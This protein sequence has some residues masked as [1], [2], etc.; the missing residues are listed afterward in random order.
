METLQ[1]TDRESVFAPI[2]DRVGPEA[3]R[4]DLSLA[5][6]S[7]TQIRNAMTVDVE[8][9]FHVAAL[10]SVI[11]R[12]DW[13]R[14]EYRAEESTR[15]L[16]DLFA[17]FEISATFFVLGWV[18]RRSPALV[19]QI[20]DAGHEVACH[21]LSHELIYRQTPKDFAL[22][23]AESKSLLEDIIG[24]SVLGYRAASWSITRQSLWA[25]DVIHDL[26]FL[27]DSSIF[28]IHHDRY[29]IPGAPTRVGQVTSPSG[30]RI[31]EFPPST[32]TILGVRVPVAG[33]GYFRLLPYSLTRFG[34]KQVNAAGEPFIFYLHPWE[35]DVDQ[36]RI[37]A[38]WLSRLRHYT[39]LDKTEVRLRKLLTEF[40]C[41]TVRAVLQEKGLLN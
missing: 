24:E 28:P 10:A 25:L 11:K 2:R 14:M 36:P 29:G 30:H 22:E 18:A 26:G 19:R 20:H 1:K 39:N 13:P 12:D 31:V 32:A 33:G 3:D 23:T 4:A 9:Y 7:G 35:V 8:D 40:K 21:G 34:L 38:S 17:Q 27:Y 15:K 37:G 16:L 6:E 41:T 5:R